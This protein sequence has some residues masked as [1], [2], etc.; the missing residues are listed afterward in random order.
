M[1]S[2][3]KLAGCMAF[4]FATLGFYIG[5]KGWY[6]DQMKKGKRHDDHDVFYH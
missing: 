6:R 4:L 3:L 1:G 5:I 2:L